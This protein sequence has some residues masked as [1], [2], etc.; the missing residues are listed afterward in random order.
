MNRWNSIYKNEGRNYSTPQEALAPIIGIF[1]KR[2]VKRVLDLGCGA[3]ANL[4]LLAKNGFEVYGFDVSAEALKL[5]K[6]QLAESG[7]KADLH[8]GD[9]RDALPYENGFFDA[10]VSV[11]VLNHGTISEI[12][13]TIKNIERVLRPGGLLFITVQARVA[14][15]H[16]VKIKM[17]DSRTYVPIEGSETGIVHYTFNMKILHKEFCNFKIHE[18][19]L[20]LGKEPWQRYYI[21]LAELKEKR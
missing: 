17:L 19:R 10:V 11:R 7:L 3:G 13:K 12:R 4:V 16:R 14:R 15:K 18:L 20:D 2:G 9:M 1:K 21:M 6:A 5:A 8:S